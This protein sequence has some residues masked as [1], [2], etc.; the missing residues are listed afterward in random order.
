MKKSIFWMFAAILTFCS[1]M[2]LSSCSS[3]ED[4]PAL[5]PTTPTYEEGKGDLVNVWY[6]E[7]EATGT[8][9]D[10]N[11]EDVSYTSVI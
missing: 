8:V 9:K 6:S 4:N 11:N 1:A 5:T 3:Q 2:V 10:D 7:Y